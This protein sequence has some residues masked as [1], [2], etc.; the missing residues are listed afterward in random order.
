[1]W[2]CNDLFT[3]TGGLVVRKSKKSS[4]SAI[5][6]AIIQKLCDVYKKKLL[7]NK[8]QFSVNKHNKTTSAERC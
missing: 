4:V 7:I 8:F 1:M 2:V 6:T 5:V 3:S